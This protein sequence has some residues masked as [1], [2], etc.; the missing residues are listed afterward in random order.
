MPEN[1]QERR[2][3]TI[4]LNLNAVTLCDGESLPVSSLT[5]DLASSKVGFPGSSLTEDR[6][7]HPS[8][9]YCRLTCSMARLYADMLQDTHSTSPI[10]ISERP[11]SLDGA[12]QNSMLLQQQ[13]MLLT[14]SSLDLH[15]LHNNNSPILKATL[16]HHHK[17][18]ISSH[19][20]QCLFIHSHFTT[21][22]L[23]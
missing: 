3:I 10:T 17:K 15:P 14:E 4:E 1:N 21:P 5:F 7:G 12:R 9:T 16:T 6:F 13:P 8:T 23:Q 18:I 20:A 22:N 2:P 19:D 11:C